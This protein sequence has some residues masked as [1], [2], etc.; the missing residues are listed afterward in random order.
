MI[1]N[2]AQHHLLSDFVVQ[3]Y[4][5]HSLSCGL[6][7]LGQ[8]IPVFMLKITIDLSGTQR[9][10]L[11]G[12]SEPVPQVASGAPWTGGQRSHFQEDL[13]T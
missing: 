13:L 9:S 8:T 2:F 10:E 11:W 12:D 7:T 3:I 6:S 4:T 5:L 1:R